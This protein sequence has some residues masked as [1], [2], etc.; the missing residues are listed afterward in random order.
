MSLFQKINKWRVLPRSKGKRRPHV[1][2][3]PLVLF[4]VKLVTTT[5]LVVCILLH[6]RTRSISYSEPQLGHMKSR[7]LDEQSSWPISD[8]FVIGSN[9]TRHT[10]SKNSTA[11]YSGCKRNLYIMKIKRSYKHN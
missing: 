6:S 9:F 3:A 1:R 7:R 10:F 11:H 8:N 2:F 5:T 4:L